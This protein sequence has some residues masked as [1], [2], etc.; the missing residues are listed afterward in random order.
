MSLQFLYLI[1]AKQCCWI[2]IG[3]ADCLLLQTIPARCHTW[4]SL[5]IQGWLLHC[6]QWTAMISIRYFWCTHDTRLV[7]FKCSHNFRILLH[8]KSNNS[9]HLFMSYW[10]GASSHWFNRCQSITEIGLGI[11]MTS[12]SGDV[13]FYI[14]LSCD[15]WHVSV[16]VF[17]TTCESFHIFVT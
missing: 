14:L 12:I 9:R 13:T 15:F 5:R 8:L 16:F 3:C 6:P 10:A 2:C 1:R 11:C 4:L 7:D 17:I